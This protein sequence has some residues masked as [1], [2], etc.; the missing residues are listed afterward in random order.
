[1]S[2]ASKKQRHEAKRKAKRSAIRRRE[3]VSP[4]KRLADAPGEPECWISEDFEA[5]GQM[6][7]FA[8]KRGAGFSGMAAFLVD[9]GVV[10]LK[11]AWVRMGLAKDEFADA[12]EGCRRRGI[13]M[14]RSS[15]EE[16]RRW[17]AG[18]LRWAHD[19][20]MRLPREWAKPA[21]LIGGVGDWQSADISAF[22]KEFAGHPEDLRQRLVGES[23]DSYLRRDD[24]RF[25]LATDAPYMDQET[26]EYVGGDRELED[27]S[28]EELED[29]AADIPE[30]ELNA[31]AARLAPAV[32]GLAA[33]TTSWLN[34]Q[35]ESPSAE[36]REAWSSVML[37]SMLSNKAMP[38]ADDEE[39]ADFGFELLR[40]ISGRITGSRAA[41]HQRAVGQVLRHLETDSMMMQKAVLKHGT[42]LEQ[43]GTDERTG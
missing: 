19:N 11:D 40:D 12:I 25:I 22:V 30:E 28:A 31:L 23:L 24:V 17:I 36:L 39:R 14:R 9:R 16:L 32:E 29:I 27:L 42:S 20:G 13:E 26:G 21:S 37:A 43:P 5:M 35:D 4:V 34:A 18:G 6:Q 10:G 7:L 41:E 38:D 15:P 3:S 2:K 1:M 33:Q 8:Y